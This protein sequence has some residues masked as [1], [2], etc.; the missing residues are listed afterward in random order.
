[1]TTIIP[2]QPLPRRTES[3]MHTRAV[4]AAA[5]VLL[6]AMQQG[7]QTSTGLAIALDSARLLN[8]PETAARVTELEIER[9]T[10]NEALS[11]AAEALREMRDRIAELEAEREALAER[12]RAGQRWQRG[13]NPELVSENY[14]SQSELREIFGISLTA[15][16]EDEGLSGPCDC[17]EGAV[18]YT[19]SD[20]P[21]EQRATGGDQ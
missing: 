2:D 20:C 4:N 12:L 19:A 3:G 8:S 5:G 1:M 10:T 11:D 15:P 9:H 17:G 18:H 13:R 21:A 6:A 14:V 7:R 16:W